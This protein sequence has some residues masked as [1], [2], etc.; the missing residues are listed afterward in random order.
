LLLIALVVALTIGA[1]R[2]SRPPTTQE[3]VR[4]ITSE[5]RC[6]VCQGETVADSNA[7]ISQDIR[8]LV[9]QRVQAGQSDKAILDYVVHQYPGTLLDPP[10]KGIGLIVWALPVIAVAA[11][12]AGLALAFRRWRGRPGVVVT[13]DDRELV[14]DALRARK[15]RT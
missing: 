10:A 3:R 2:S 7:L 15:T 1:T 8:S 6:P 12:I 13:P 5:L 4:H 9:Q 14:E 11:S